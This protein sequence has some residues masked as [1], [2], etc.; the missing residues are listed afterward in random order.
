MG[1]TQLGI[2]THG[3]I[4]H[5]RLKKIQTEKNAEAAALPPGYEGV[6]GLT[7]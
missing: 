6:S 7:M 1:K 3:I 2:I 5:T 4:A